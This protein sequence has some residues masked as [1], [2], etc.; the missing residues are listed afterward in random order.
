MFL[1]YRFEV[2]SD[3]VVYF[4]ALTLYCCGFLLLSAPF[5]VSSSRLILKAASVCVFPLTEHILGW[6]FFCTWSLLTCLPGVFE[7]MCSSS[8]RLLLWVSLF[9]FPQPLLDF[10]LGWGERGVAFRIIFLNLHIL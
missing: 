2:F 1:C 10:V 9:L 8:L 5:H 7:P 4:V 6:F 3:F